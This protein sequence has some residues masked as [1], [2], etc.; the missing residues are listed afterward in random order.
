LLVVVG[1][2]MFRAT[3]VHGAFDMYAGMLGFNG[4]GPEPQLWWQVER[5]QLM[6]LAIAYF[7]MFAGPML[8]AYCLTRLSRVSLK[9]AS[10]ALPVLF[11][12]AALKLSAQN[13][14]PFLY[15]QF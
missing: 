6:T 12:L 2:V 9:V 14:S 7:L 5:F 11:V 4:V 13:Y 10:I 3:S 15:F 8:S 1:W